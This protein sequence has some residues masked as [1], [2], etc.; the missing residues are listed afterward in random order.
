M[1]SGPTTG[2]DTRL[3]NLIRSLSLYGPGIRSLGALGSGLCILGPG[4]RSLPV[5]IMPHSQVSFNSRQTPAVPEREQGK[6][7]T[8]Q[9]QCHLPG[10]RDTPHPLLQQSGHH[11]YNSLPEHRRNPVKSA[12]DAHKQRLFLL[13][14]RQHIEPV[15]G[16][17]VRC[18]SKCYHIEYH[19]T[20]PE[21]IRTHG[22]REKRKRHCND[23]LH[24]QNPP[25]LALEYVHDRT[26]EGFDHPR[27]IQK[28]RVERKV[29]VGHPEALEESHGDDVHYEI[30]YSFREIKARHPCPRMGFGS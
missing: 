15:R 23:G 30:W 17:V 5:R 2:R 19:K 24:H 8:A 13:A 26:P 16:Y 18:R 3:R 28:R 1:H 10:R 4:A 29:S 14:E 6:Q 21:H 11:H 9:Q 27:K 25:S 22:Q 12:P 7:R 20:Q